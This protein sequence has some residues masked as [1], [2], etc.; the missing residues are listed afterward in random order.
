MQSRH[1]LSE[2]SE[3]ETDKPNEKINI[4]ILFKK[5]NLNIKTLKSNVLVKS[6]NMFKAR[7]NCTSKCN[8]T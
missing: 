2:I 7:S 3:F 1:L 4:N 8:V 6:T 5:Y